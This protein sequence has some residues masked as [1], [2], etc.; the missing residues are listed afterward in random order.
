MTH[1]RWCEAC[2]KQRCDL[3]DNFHRDHTFRRHYSGIYEDDETCQLAWGR[4]FRE[5]RKKAQICDWR[6]DLK[7]L[8]INLG[9]NQRDSNDYSIALSDDTLLGKTV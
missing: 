3:I 6:E 8:D 4:G 9:I 2:I 5:G 7:D 1:P